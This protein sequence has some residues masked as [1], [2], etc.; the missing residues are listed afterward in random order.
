MPRGRIVKNNRGHTIG[1]KEIGLRIRAIRIDR[2]L[3]QSELGTQLDVSFQQIQKYEKGVNRLSVVR[4][5]KIARI[6]KTSPLELMG[7]DD[8]LERTAGVIAFDKEAYRLAKSFM[9]LSD[10]HKHRVRS[11]IDAITITYPVEE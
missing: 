6:L 9:K 7:W 10:D 11:L 2:K 8:K 3:S 5:M 4:L 1:D